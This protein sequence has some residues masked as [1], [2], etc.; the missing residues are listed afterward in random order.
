MKYQ[1]DELWT[2]DLCALFLF[3]YTPIILPQ[4]WLMWFAAVGQSFLIGR[5]LEDKHRKELQDS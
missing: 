4:A 5:K 3:M 1:K 2:F